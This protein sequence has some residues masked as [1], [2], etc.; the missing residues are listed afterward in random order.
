MQKE[1][2]L[3]IAAILVFGFAGFSPMRTIIVE[4]PATA[5]KEFGTHVNLRNDLS[6]DVEKVNIRILIYDLGLTFYSSSFDMDKKDGAG[7]WVFGDMPP[8]VPAG[9]YLARI[10]ASNDDF[11]EVKHVYIAVE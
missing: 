5:G 3:M 4:E 11:K 7:L 1:I 2:G 8:Y 9:D 6:L 10:T